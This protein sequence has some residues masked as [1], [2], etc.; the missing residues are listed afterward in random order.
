[1]SLSKIKFRTLGYF[2][3]LRSSPH[4]NLWSISVCI[5][6][7]TI[8][9]RHTQTMTRGQW[10]VIEG[11]GGTGGRWM[12]WP[13]DRRS[14]WSLGSWGWQ[15]SVPRSSSSPWITSCSM[16]FFWRCI[17]GIKI[18]STQR[19]EKSCTSL[20][21]SWIWLLAWWRFPYRR[22][23][24]VCWFVGVEVCQSIYAWTV[25]NLVPSH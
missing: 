20:Q 7:S 19:V 11:M 16:D 25:K 17:S 21:T 9:Y 8:H 1:M 10:G 22:W 14:W 6:I 15:W 12:L 5:T 2:L 24:A 18:C 23:I 3:T 13:S 4:I